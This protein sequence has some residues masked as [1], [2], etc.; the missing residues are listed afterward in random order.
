MSSPLVPNDPVSPSR[1]ALF[2]TRNGADPLN[3][4]IALNVGVP[5]TIVIGVPP[6]TPVPI[7]SPA[8]SENSA[9]SSIG[10]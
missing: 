8:G 5:D 10:Q 7:T 6:C 3:D 1:T 2:S 4:V 9:S